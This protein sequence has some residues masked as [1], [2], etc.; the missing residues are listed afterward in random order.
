VAKVEDQKI[1][2]AGLYKFIRHPGYLGQLTIFFGIS[3]SVSN[4]LSVLLMMVP[5]MFGY[6]Y[7]IQVE[8]R[9]MLKEMGENYLEYQ[10]RTK[11]IIPLIF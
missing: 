1:I 6:F 7:R 3:I 4:W 8:E 2:E 9:F 11:S 5:V 10:A